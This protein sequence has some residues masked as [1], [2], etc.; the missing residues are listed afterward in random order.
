MTKLEI[1]SVNVSGQKGTP[2][3]SREEIAIDASGVV[4]DAHAGRWH[5][6][7]SLLA[8]ESIDRFAVRLGRPIG[9][10]E[11]GENLTFSGTPSQ[12]IAPLDR[13]AVGE[14]E[15]EITQI[16]KKCHGAGCAIFQQVGQCVM[17]VEGLFARVIRGGIVCRGDRGEHRPRP[18]QCMVITLSDRAAAGDYVDRSGPRIRE[19]LEAHFASGRWHPAITQCVLPDDAG[20]LRQRVREG[21]HSGIDVIFTS[22]GTGV[23]PR[24]ITPDTVA[25]LCERQLP[26]VM[27]HIRA[28]FGA[29]NPQAR[30]SR[31][32]AG[33]AGKTQIYTLPGS[34]RA[35]EEYLGEIL[36]TMEHLVFMLQG[37]DVHE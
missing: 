15:L 5:R 17:P 29:A 6:Q 36:A 25:P 16:G 18:F 27:E 30:L 2:K 14:V 24:D 34:V 13:I 31:G 28:K 10:G 11:F 3:T 8:Q 21:I 9:P 19:L 20:Q 12:D 33:V 32:V 37:W 22:G 26:G 4:G 7:V 35:V 1:R 23:G